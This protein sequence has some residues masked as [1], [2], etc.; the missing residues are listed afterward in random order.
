MRLLKKA[1]I[2][3]LVGGAFALRAHTGIL[4][5]TKDFDLMMSQDSVRRALTLFQEAGFRAEM[6]FTHWLAKVHHGELFID[7]IFNSGNGLCP[8]DPLWMEY[9]QDRSVLGVPAKL[10]PAEEMIWQK[11]FIM[12]RERFDGAD[13][14]HLLLKGSPEMDWNRLLMRFRHH[15]AVLLSHLLLFQYAYP[16]HRQNI[17]S[18]VMR[19]LLRKAS[20]Q[21]LKNLAPEVCRGTY[22][23]REQYLPDIDRWGFEDARRLGEMAL[24]LGEIETWTSAIDHAKFAH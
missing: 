3:F 18:D 11:A 14:L 16:S 1:K 13:I 15:E 12:E 19:Q 8:V 17:P 23:S 9:A 20:A 7:L 10:C 5:D 24:T 2:P 21:P 22:L 4:R 6:A